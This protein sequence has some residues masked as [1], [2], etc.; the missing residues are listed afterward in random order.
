MTI[1]AE[2]LKALIAQDH[3]HDEDD[4]VEGIA[5]RAI[6]KGYGSLT[7]R[8]QAVLGPFLNMNCPGVSDPGDHHNNCQRK[9]GGADLL[10]A[11]EISYY[12]DAILCD[13]CRDESDGYSAHWARIQA[14]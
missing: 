10:A 12:Y 9:L 3:F 13:H 14:E 7:P 4:M 1:E 5:K 8:Q 6:D 11:I 2:I